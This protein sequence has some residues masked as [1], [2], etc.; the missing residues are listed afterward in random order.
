VRE[1]SYKLVNGD[2]AHRRPGGVGDLVA[3]SSDTQ[4]ENMIRKWFYGADRPT[5]GP[6][7]TYN[8]ASG[9]L[10]Q[11]GI[12]YK[13]VIQGNVG[14]C[15]LLADL[16]AVALQKPSAIRDM[17]IDNYDGT[18]TVRYF[19]YNVAHYVTVDRYLPT[20]SNGA[21]WSA[22]STPNVRYD[23]VSNELWVALAEKAYV[24]ISQSSWT[25]KYNEY[26][27]YLGINGGNAMH[28]LDQIIGG[29]ARATANP[30]DLTKMQNDF[31][32]GHSIALHS[33]D[34]PSDNIFGYHV[35]AFMGYSRDTC[36]YSFY[37]PHGEVVT[38]TAEQVMRNFSHW[39]SI[40]T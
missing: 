4:M 35:Y 27:T 22:K 6:G 24:Q 1:L 26:N 31:I 17:F 30:M 40:A 11:D 28:P 13:D 16:A 12:S 23:D 20:D 29:T 3:G 36:M 2:L 8:Y 9:S 34:S 32:A 33:V 37:N 7:M 38:L 19:H 15:Y 18:F 5:P 14:D 10:F 21:I 25:G 39:V